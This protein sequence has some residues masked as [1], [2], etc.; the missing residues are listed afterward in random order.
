MRKGGN[1]KRHWSQV[2][3]RANKK[4]KRNDQKARLKRSGR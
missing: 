4:S 2:K 3:T 1:Y